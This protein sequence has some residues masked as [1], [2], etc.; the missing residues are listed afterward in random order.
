MVH[1]QGKKI[2]KLKKQCGYNNQNSV[3]NNQNFG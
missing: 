3:L 2:P 1:M